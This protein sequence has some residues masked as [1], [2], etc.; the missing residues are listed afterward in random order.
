MPLS[1]VYTPE[2]NP[3]IARMLQRRRQAL[4]CAFVAKSEGLRPLVRDLSQG[5]SIGLIVDRR[6]D[7]GEMLPFFGR[8]AAMTTSP[9][10]LALKFGCQLVPT[11]VERTG[12]SRFRVTVESDHLVRGTS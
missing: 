1:V 2:P 12:R 9:A 7:R 6:N 10:R 5:R 4:G 11:R 8:E 3:L